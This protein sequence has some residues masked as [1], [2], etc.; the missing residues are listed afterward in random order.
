MNQ[1]HVVL[2]ASKAV[3]RAS[4]ALDDLHSYLIQLKGH[5]LPQGLQATS[6]KASHARELV[7]EIDAALTDPGLILS[8]SE[9]NSESVQAV[10]VSENYSPNPGRA[11]QTT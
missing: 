10:S 4:N 8:A 1:R 7:R 2:S 6:V 9:T 3:L 5:A 11:E